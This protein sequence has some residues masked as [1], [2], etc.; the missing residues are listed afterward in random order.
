MAINGQADRVPAPERV[1]LELR[2][3]ILEGE[4]GPGHPL[5]T[6]AV[7]EP[8]G[9]REGRQGVPGPD[10]T[11]EDRSP[12]LEVHAFRGRHTVG[13]AVYR[14]GQF[15]SSGRGLGVRVEDGARKEDVGLPARPF[16]PERR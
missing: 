5:T 4:V 16:R 14:H 6:L 7:A 9:Y 13:L 1:Y 15:P 10:L 12:Q 3:A 11:F 2:R 8:L